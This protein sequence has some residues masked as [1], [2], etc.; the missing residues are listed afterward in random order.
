M[1]QSDRFNVNAPELPV[2]NLEGFID[3]VEGLLHNICGPWRSLLFIE[4][5]RDLITDA[6]AEIKGRMAQ[7][8]SVL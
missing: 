3:E 6:Y 4:S 2:R 5:D 1:P 8:V 7:L